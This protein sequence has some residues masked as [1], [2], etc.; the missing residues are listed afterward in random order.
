MING[1][2]NNLP[3]HPLPWDFPDETGDVIWDEDNAFVTKKEMRDTVEDSV[4]DAMDSITMRNNGDGT[5]TLMIGDREAG[6]IVVPADKYLTDVYLDKETGEL[7]FVVKNSD[8]DIN[9]IRVDIKLFVENNDDGVFD[10]GDM[11]DLT[12]D[13]VERDEW[14]V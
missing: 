12:D 1:N 10:L 9:N 6:T 11:D 3:Y 4:A 14:A 7:V 5:Y 13:T 2:N 8:G